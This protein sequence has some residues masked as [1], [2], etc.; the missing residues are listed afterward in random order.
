MDA[1]FLR[2]NYIPDIQKLKNEC[3]NYVNWHGYDAPFYQRIKSRTR[4]AA[5]S[6]CRVQRSEAKFM[7]LESASSNS[8]HLEKMN[9]IIDTMEC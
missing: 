7:L 3:T 6:F 2:A 1:T 8:T 9:K 5:S 4:R